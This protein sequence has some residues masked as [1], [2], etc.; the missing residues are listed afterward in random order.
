[1]KNR[2]VPSIKKVLLYCYVRKFWVIEVDRMKKV[3]LLGGSG[4]IGRN[5]IEYFAHSEEYDI[6]A[7]TSKELNVIDEKSVTD[8]LTSQYFDI[9]LHFA[10]YGDGIDKSKDGTKMLEYNLRM[11]LNFEKNSYLYGKMYYAGSGAEYDK[12]R[13][14]IDVTEDDE[15]ENIPT[16]HYGL[17]RY[18]IDKIIRKSDNIYGLKIFGIFGPYEPWWRR[19]ISNCC[20]KVIRDIPL[21]IRQN[22]YFDY[23]WIEDFL[24]ILKCLMD[25]TPNEH[26]YNVTTGKKV[27]LLTLAHMVLKVSG[28]E[29][30]IYV[31]KE[32]MGREYTSDNTRLLKELG[33]YEFTDMEQSIA[34]LYRW[35][36]KHEDI[37]DMSRLLYQ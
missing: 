20:C 1:M 35:Y 3:L 11:F 25:K 16:D 31:C 7:P 10:V 24:N 23:I 19:F 8:Y 12:S 28:K 22:V 5:I 9:I 4:F 18:T 14:I 29:L 6:T 13:D 32:G 15:G 26:V 2:E 37:I 17:M 36:E 33:G 21:S 34:K 27:D 30:P